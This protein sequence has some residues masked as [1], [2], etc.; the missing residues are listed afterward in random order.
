LVLLI[1]LSYHSGRL[2]GGGPHHATRTVG[3]DRQTA[4]PSHAQ[5]AGPRSAPDKDIVAPQLRAGR[6]HRPWMM[7]RAEFQNGT[8]RRRIPQS[9][10]EDVRAFLAATASLPRSSRLESEPFYGASPSRFSPCPSHTSRL[11]SVAH[12][13]RQQPSRYSAGVRRSGAVVPSRADST[14]RPWARARSWQRTGLIRATR[15]NDEDLISVEC[16]DEGC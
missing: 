13:A 10:R 14:R 16:R 11:S 15:R 3:P 2:V 1:V 8:W 6:H 9:T 5:A 7:E 12:A 4:I